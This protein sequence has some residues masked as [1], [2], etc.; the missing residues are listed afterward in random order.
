MAKKVIE[1]NKLGKPDGYF[2]A[3]FGLEIIIILA[4]FFFGKGMNFFVDDPARLGVLIPLGLLTFVSIFFSFIFSQEKMLKAFNDRINEKEQKFYAEL[5][6]CKNI[7]DVKDWT[8]R[9]KEV[10]EYKKYVNPILWLYLSIFISLI[11]I[12]AYFTNISYKATIISILIHLNL[13]MVFFLVT[14]VASI[15]V[16]YLLKKK[17]REEQIKEIIR[18]LK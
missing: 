18:R 5:K 14:S 3:L 4:V 13:L 2:S 10:R 17:E 16:A 15:M 12:T 11:A 6:F 1:K 8:E 9:N 7:E